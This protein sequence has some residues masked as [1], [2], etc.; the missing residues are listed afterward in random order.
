MH[1]EYEVTFEELMSI[2]ER[3][4]KA[5]NF[6]STGDIEGS[7][8]LVGQQRAEKAMEFG[9]KMK[10]KGYNIYISGGR[11]CGKIN[12][13]KNILNAASEKLR[14]P[15]DWC[16]VYNFENKYNPLALNFPAGLGRIFKQDME[17]LVGETTSRLP[18]AFSS[19]EYERQK[20]DILEDY[21][22]KKSMLVDELNS[23]AE[24]NNLQLK[25]TGTGFAFTPL[26]DGKPLNEGE[27]DSISTIDKESILKNV[28]EVR[29]SALDILRKLKNAEKES[30]DKVKKLDK[31]IGLF[32]IESLISGIRQKYTDNPKAVKYI[33]SVQRDMV[34][35]IYDFI[36]CEENNSCD[37][38]EKGILMKYKIN[39]MV[40][41]GSTRGGP[42]IYDP[43]P[44]FNNLMGT[45]EY[46]SKQG[47]MVTDFLMI[48]AGSILKANGGYLILKI[49]DL[50]K[51]YQSWE[52]LKRVIESGELRPE[53]LRSQ[54]D[55]ITIATIK[56]EPI[57]VNMKVI[58][59]GSER[60]YQLLCEHDEEFGNL[61]K[62]K[63]EFD[64]DMEKNETN[65]LQMAQFIGYYC[66]NNKIRHLDSPAVE[67]VI[68]YSSRLAGSSR[69]LS[70]QLEKVTELLCESN[71]L[72]ETA[73]R[74]Y[75]GSA[76]I[77]RAIYESKKRVNLIEDKVIRQYIDKKIIINI[78]GEAVGQI[79]GLSIVEIG[80]YA[81]G[82]PYKI[83]AS[84]YM[85][86][87]G[88]IN[89]EREAQMSGSI[90]NKSVMIIAGYLGGKYA[91]EIPLSITAHICFEQLYGFIDGD[92]ASAAELYTILSSL[93]EIPLKQAIAVTGSLNQMGEIQPVGGI[94]EK[95]EGFFKV[96]SIYGLDGEQGVIIPFQNVDDLALEDDVMKG[97]KSGLFH[98]FAIRNAE[99]GISILTGMKP[100]SRDKEGKYEEGTF[101][102]YVDR[103]LRNMIKNYNALEQI[104]HQPK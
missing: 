61:F 73:G 22:N 80:D 59:V 35:N 78:K 71:A 49:E 6:R 29:A 69:R 3:F 4:R 102:Y 23:I 85:G 46:E 99:D 17:R 95:I 11:G 13:A 19:E 39:L 52:G 33:D 67:A 98:I 41:N 26:S 10:G 21:H 57:P 90:H 65:I 55:L 28:A 60:I 44:T 92:S 30:E 32:V 14:V 101:N 63:V 87:N 27:Y 68:D 66:R 83:T 77:K 75:I 37:K 8:R 58:L 50:L 94:N 12:Y 89:I 31:E 81:F 45:V 24:S 97:I 51:N 36:N 48:S 84:T 47:T 42:V 1:R 91:R 96:C 103:K 7:D 79:N 16:Y 56:P 76:D 93:S 2:N 15:D 20:N 40:D 86:K 53:G 64:T 74:K 70:A 104:K 18:Q 82:K 72:A 9:I 34:N 88:I 100:G 38:E 25:V 62:V 54:L 43:N 5:L